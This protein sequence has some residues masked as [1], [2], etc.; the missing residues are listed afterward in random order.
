MVRSVSIPLFLAVLAL[1][2]LASRGTNLG[3]V[4]AEPPSS[5]ASAAESAPPNIVLFLVDDQI[6]RASCRER[7]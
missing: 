5:P 1:L 2:P 6:G 3:R 4:F 7:V